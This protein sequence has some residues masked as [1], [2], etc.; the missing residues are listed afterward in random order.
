M[1]WRYWDI[2]VTIVRCWLF[3]TCTCNRWIIFS[4]AA[5]GTK[6]TGMPPWTFVESIE[7]THED[8]DSDYAQLEQYHGSSSDL[9][10]LL[11]TKNQW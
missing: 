11:V 3:L 2:L 6:G 7:D 9:D 4:A 5:V 1:S 8:N 10:V